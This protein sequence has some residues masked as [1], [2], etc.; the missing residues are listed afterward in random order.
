MF[1]VRYIF[2]HQST[3]NP[4]MRIP[5]RSRLAILSKKSLQEPAVHLNTIDHGKANGITAVSARQ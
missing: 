4:G 2:L 5:G 1:I 3:V